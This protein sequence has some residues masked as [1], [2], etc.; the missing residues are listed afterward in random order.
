MNLHHM[1]Y[2]TKRRF[3]AAIN[4]IFREPEI[5]FPRADFQNS[6][7]FRDSQLTCFQ[8]FGDHDTQKRFMYFNAKVLF[9]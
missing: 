6:A 2:I 3:S 8:V 1:V 9:A 5:Y 7:I 4:F